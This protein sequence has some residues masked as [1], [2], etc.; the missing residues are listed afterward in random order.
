MGFGG[1]SRW[2]ID[3]GGYSIDAALFWN[4]LRWGHEIRGQKSGCGL[5]CFGRFELST[6]KPVFRLCGSRF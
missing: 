4:Q 1:L 2:I 5:I 3:F 6:A